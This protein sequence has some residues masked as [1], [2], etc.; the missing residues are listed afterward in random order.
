MISHSIEQLEEQRRDGAFFEITK[1]PGLVE[2][3]AAG[4]DKVPYQWLSMVLGPPP[5]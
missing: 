5:L 3:S 2:S 1:S 4:G